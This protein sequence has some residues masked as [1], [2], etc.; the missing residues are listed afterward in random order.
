[1][2]WRELLAHPRDRRTQE[3]LQDVSMEVVR[4]EF[5]GLLGQNGAGKSTLF[6][7]LAGLVL[8]DG[9]SVD[10]AGSGRSD[11]PGGGVALVV[12]SERS[13]YW[14]LS[15][16]ENL[17]LYAALHDMDRGGVTDRIEETLQVVGLA[18]TGQKQVGLFSSG[19]RQR[20]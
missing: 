10:V 9:G 12:P 5:F 16:R 8:P 11:V 4:G 14:R 15:A 1:R 3:A 19:M 13:L 2:S 7:I 17:R 18:D 20:L 6:R